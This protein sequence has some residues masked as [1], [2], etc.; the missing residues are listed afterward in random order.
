[1]PP[2]VDCIESV[3][4]TAMCACTLLRHLIRKNDGRLP[5]WQ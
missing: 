3:P 4:Y 5:G 2:A 1:M